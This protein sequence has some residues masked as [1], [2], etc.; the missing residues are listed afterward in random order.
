MK[1]DLKAVIYTRVSTG[2]QAENGT[3]LSGR[4]CVKTKQS[5][6]ARQLLVFMKMQ[7]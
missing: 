6:S 7:V 2:E 5:L 1:D 3:S 4:K